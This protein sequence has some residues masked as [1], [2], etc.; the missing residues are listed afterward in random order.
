MWLK[1]KFTQSLL[2][3]CAFLAFSSPS[4]AVKVAAVEDSN[5]MTGPN[6]LTHHISVGKFFLLNIESFLS[7]IIKSI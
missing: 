7:S 1:L 6:V 3:F 5:I 4:W 2:F